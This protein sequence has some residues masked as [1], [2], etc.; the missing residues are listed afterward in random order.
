MSD[1]GRKALAPLI[2]ALKAD[3]GAKVT[4]SGYHSAAGTLAQNQDLA[5]RRAFAVRDAFRSAGI[6]DD[7][8]AL[9]KPQAAE[10]NLAGEDPKARHVEVAF[11]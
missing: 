7:R 1:G 4:V 5:K 3:P 10:A 9:E 2:D 11:K 6:A 8:V